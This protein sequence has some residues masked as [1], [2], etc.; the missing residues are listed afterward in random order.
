MIYKYRRELC[1]LSLPGLAPSVLPSNLY[2]IP[3]LEL[4]RL[5]LEHC[6]HLPSEL[7]NL[8]PQPS[9]LP[10]APVSTS[11]IATST[12]DARQNQ[13]T[14]HP[15]REW[16]WGDYTT[17][18]LNAFARVASRHIIDGKVEAQAKLIQS[19]LE[20]EGFGERTAKVFVQLLLK[21]SQAN[22]DIANHCRRSAAKTPRSAANLP[23]LT[24]IAA[25]S[26]EGATEAAPEDVGSTSLTDK[27][28]P[29]NGTWDAATDPEY[30]GW[31]KRRAERDGREPDAAEEAADQA[32]FSGLLDRLIEAGVVKLW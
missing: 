29:I 23:H 26:S 6:W 16:P 19:D 4:A 18:A 5:G 24:P 25:H 9:P 7:D 22:E 32:F 12:D 2:R 15:P 13:I 28:D 1:V 14:T 31:L 8:I 3:L 27:Y 20:E 10:T 30:Q 11:P 17:E 21:S